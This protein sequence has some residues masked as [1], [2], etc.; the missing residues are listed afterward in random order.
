MP[1]HFYGK[2]I[3]RIYTPGRFDLYHRYHPAAIYQVSPLMQPLCQTYLPCVSAAS[4]PIDC[5]QCV[6]N[7]GG[8]I[9]CA[10]SI[11]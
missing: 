8:P 4:N 7:N 9:T 5:Q 11:C 2:R 10:S 3:G 1:N 6:L